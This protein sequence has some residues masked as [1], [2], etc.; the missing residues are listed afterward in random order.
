MTDSNNLRE[1][2]THFSEE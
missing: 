1:Q 2:L